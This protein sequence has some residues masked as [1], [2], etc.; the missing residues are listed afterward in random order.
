MGF[1]R[2]IIIAITFFV[3]ASCSPTRVVKTL[4]K[5]EKQLGANFG[6]AM[7]NYAGIPTPL[8]LT[9]INYAQGLDTGV[10][11]TGAF[12][13]TDALFGVMHIEAGLGIRAFE[14]KSEKFG[15]TIS[16]SIQ[17]MYDIW[18]GA[19]RTYPQ[20]EAISYWQYGEKPNLFY[21][22]IGSWIELI[23][24]KAHEEVQKNEL[25]PYLMIGHQFNKPKWAITTEVKYLGFQHDNV[26]LVPGYISP[27][28]K[29]ALGIYVGVSRRL[30]R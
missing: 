29:G 13:T 20:L 5:G 15:L 17:L 4:D 1:T 14:T 9:S 8:P 2:I 16:P 19:F 7:I 12:H 22:G 3:A 18:E 11:V 24:E 10:T 23:K 30:V 26:S 28:N 6:G 25:L 27:M 21:G